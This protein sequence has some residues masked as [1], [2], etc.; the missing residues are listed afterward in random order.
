MS[1]WRT[2]YFSSAA[3]VLTSS[4][5]IWHVNK[6]D[7]SNSISLGMVDEFDFNSADFNNAWARLTCCLSNCPLTRDVLDIYLI[8]FS[9]SVISEIQ[10]LWLSSFYSKCSKFNIDLQNA[11]KN[12]EQFFCF[13]DNWLWIVILKLSLLRTGYFS[14]AANV[15]TSGPKIWHINKRDFFEHN[16]VASDQWIR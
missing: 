5:K 7:F 9:E 15:L 8:T 2:R 4:S 1:L 6:R 11:A 10:N 3:N 16:F 12:S 14:S 13:S